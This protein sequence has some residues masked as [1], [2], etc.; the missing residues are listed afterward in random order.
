MTSKT[1]WTRCCSVVRLNATVSRR[2][3]IQAHRLH[4]RLQPQS[5]R[6]RTTT[7]FVATFTPATAAITTTHIKVV[8]QVEQLELTIKEIQSEEFI[9]CQFSSARL[10]NS[11]QLIK[12]SEAD[13]LNRPPHLIHVS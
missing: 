10:A 4:R 8:I 6:Q 13:V 2:A 9:E 3:C 5:P 12:S 11:V 1:G 7:T